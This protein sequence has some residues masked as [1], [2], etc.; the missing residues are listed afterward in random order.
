MVTLPWHSESSLIVNGNNA[1]T[2]FSFWKSIYKNRP[3]SDIRPRLVLK[4]DGN[5]CPWGQPEGGQGASSGCVA[6]I[7]S[8]TKFLL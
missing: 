1:E 5:L 6:L 8:R 4:R 3:Q 2:S 7:Q